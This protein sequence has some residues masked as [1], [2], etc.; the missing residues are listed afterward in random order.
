MKSRVYLILGLSFLF[1]G[2]LVLLNSLKGFTG[3]AIFENVDPRVSL[4]AGGWFLAS[5]VIVFLL[6]KSVKT[7]KKR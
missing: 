6:K 4:F 3:N 1:M 2:L 5:A 7:S